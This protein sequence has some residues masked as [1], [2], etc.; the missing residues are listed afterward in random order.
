MLPS[1]VARDT[2]EVIIPQEGRV[3][4]PARGMGFP[5]PT[6]LLKFCPLTP[7]LNFHISQH[8]SYHNLL[9]SQRIET[10]SLPFLGYFK[11]W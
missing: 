8:N 9:T 1:Q 11:R 7:S 10:F 6:F 2:S 3:C 5:G 4:R